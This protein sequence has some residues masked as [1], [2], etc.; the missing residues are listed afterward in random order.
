VLA[1]FRNIAGN[2]AA[3]VPTI[4]KCDRWSPHD[5]VFP[6]RRLP[7][8]TSVRL[9]QSQRQKYLASPCPLSDSTPSTVSIPKRRPLSEPRII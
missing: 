1:R 5:R 9:P 3:V 6:L 2:L 8:Q 7:A 4:A